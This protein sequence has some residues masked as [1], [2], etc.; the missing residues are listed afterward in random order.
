MDRA[1]KWIWEKGEACIH[2]L[3]TFVAQYYKKHSFDY[4][5]FILQTMD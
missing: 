4:V 1:Q 2:K 5:L 3:R